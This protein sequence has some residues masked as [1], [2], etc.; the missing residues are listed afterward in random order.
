M[1]ADSV[2]HIDMGINY[3]VNYINTK[4]QN[5]RSPKLDPNDQY[6]GLTE[7]VFNERLN[8]E[9]QKVATRLGVTVDDLT[10]SQR[11]RAERTFKFKVM[12]SNEEG[13]ST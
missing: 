3:A 7:D 6:L 4:G 12:K 5:P 13:G 8:E 11:Q 9:L 2:Y 10:D 1:A